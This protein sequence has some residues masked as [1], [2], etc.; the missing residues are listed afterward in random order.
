MQSCAP[1]PTAQEL[2][3]MLFFQACLKESFRL[4]PTVPSISRMTPDDIVLAGYH[5]PAK[6]LCL[7]NWTII[8]RDARHFPDAN[9]FRPERWI[10]DKTEK[11]IPAMSVS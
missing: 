5:I 9:V 8:H 4:F 1:T 10:D 2:G 7:F 3:K 11:K 6:T